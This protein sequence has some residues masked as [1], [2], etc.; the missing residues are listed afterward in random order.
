MAILLRELSSY[1]HNSFT[2]IVIFP[3]RFSGWRFV[4]IQGEISIPITLPTRFGLVEAH[5]TQE[6]N[7]VYTSGT[8]WLRSHGPGALPCTSRH[9]HFNR[10]FV[11]DC[12]KIRAST[13]LSALTCTLRL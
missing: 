6:L 3:A 1:C 7:A 10:I 5:E 4:R 2:C 8:R 11:S 13:S 9:T 12:E